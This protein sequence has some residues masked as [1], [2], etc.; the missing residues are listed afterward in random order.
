MT[1]QAIDYS[2]MS[3]EELEKL[4]IDEKKKANIDYSTLSDD[5]LM[6]LVDKDKKISSLNTTDDWTEYL[7]NSAKLGVGDTIELV[8]AGLETLITEPI[9][10]VIQNPGMLLDPEQYTWNQLSKGI[11]FTE[12]SEIGG[13]FMSNLSEVQSGVT[14]LTG[15]DPSLTTKDDALRYV[16]RGVRT[17]TDLPGYIGAPLKTASMIQ[18]GLGLGVVGTSAEVGGDVGAEVEKTF[19][20][21]DTG[22]GRLIGGLTGGISP[23]LATT[24]ATRTIVPPVKQIWE[25]YKFVKKNPELAESQY[26]AGAAKRL[27]KMIA[28]EQGVDNIDDIVKEFNRLGK[29]IDG[30]DLPLLVA[31]SDN[32]VVI[33]QVHR[34]AKTDEAFRNEVTMELKRLAGQIDQKANSIFGVRDVDIANMVGVPKTLHKKINYL[35]KEKFNVDNQIEDIGL[36][37]I[38][39]MSAKKQGEAI[40]ALVLKREKIVKAKLSPL[41]IKLTK[42]AKAAGIFIDQKGVSSIYE[43]VKNNNLRDIFGKGTKLDNRIMKYT[44]PVKTT[45]KATGISTYETPIMSFEHLDSLKRA[46]NELKRK[47]LSNTE[48]RKLND[49]DDVIREARKSMKGNYSEKLDA[50]DK[51]YYQEM[52]VPFNSAS[53]KEIGAKKYADEVAP[54]ILKNESALESFLDVAGSDGHII[55]RNAYLSKVY[56]KVVKD[57]E[58]NTSTLKAMLKKDKDLIN[59]IPGLKSELDE[60]LVD[61]G[62]LMLKRAEINEGMKIAEDAIAKNF[63]ITSN[64]EPKWDSLVNRSLRDHTYLDKVFK[65]IS[66]I[67]PVTAQ[68]VTRRIQREFVEVSLEAP[69]GAYKF[70]TDPRNRVAVRKMFKDN[71]E[72]ISQVKDLSKLGDAINKAD[73]ERLSSLVLNER[74]DW[75]AELLPGLDTNYTFSQMRD[76]ISSKSMKVFRIMTRINQGRMKI[77]VDEQIK[78][79]LLNPQ[80]LSKLSKAA[81]AFD[82]KIDNPL[83]WKKI[84]NIISETLPSYIYASSKP[85]LLNEEEATKQKIQ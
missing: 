2:S 8:S 44:G 23:T 26:A 83:K 54:I 55:A 39:K 6:A 68:A 58:I 62:S 69:K 18:R 21:G 66:E 79:I 41:Y 80:G 84:S 60:I 70:I 67:D 57:G 7:W 63:L 74:L 45:N 52:G 13:R 12:Q 78:D 81:R 46:V 65:D 19:T 40:T 75:L 51:K 76:R 35:V 3:D 56:N 43:H 31:M 61:Q 22:T 48:M 37:F 59:R 72:Y 47:P 36:K 73:V 85:V 42:D 27:L 77:K 71:P 30:K 82:F 16:G 15:A 10:G 34:L 38:P 1:T 32:P 29:Q 11:P 28:R 9:K 64:L 14:S 50:L 17:I 5:E 53:I 25:K 20:G 33:S 4:Y 24:V 49:L